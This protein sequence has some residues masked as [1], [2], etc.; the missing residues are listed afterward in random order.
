M[1]RYLLVHCLIKDTSFFFVFH[2]VAKIINPDNPSMIGWPGTFI[3]IDVLLLGMVYLVLK[4]G[5][6]H[7]RTFWF[8]ALLHLI[9]LLQV[10][11]SINLDGRI[12]SLSI[13]SFAS[14]I[15]SGFVYQFLNSKRGI[16]N[17]IRNLAG[18]E[19]KGK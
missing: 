12:V 8:G 4:I 18:I 9:L 14:A 10:W 19:P 5:K 15:I 17:Q 7:M 11:T 13:A 2:L 3:I 1:M 6:I 16:E